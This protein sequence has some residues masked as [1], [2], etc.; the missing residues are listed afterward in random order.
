[1]E[2]KYFDTSLVASPIIAPTDC[3]G[4]E[5]DPVTILC[6]NGVPQGD[7]ASSR[8]G[9][10]IAMKSLY[11]E[12]KVVCAAQANQ[13]ASDSGTTVLIAVVLDTQTNGAQ[14]N[15]EDVYINPAGDANLASSP[16][17][18]MSFTERFK[19]LKQKRI[20]IRQ[21]SMVYDGTNVE[22]AGQK[23][24]FRMAIN[25]GGMLTKFQTGTTTGYVGTIIDN[26][27]HVVAYADGTDLS[28][29]LYYN[30]RLRYRG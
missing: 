4:G 26:S 9:M 28:P 25:L 6:L 29:V 1:M 22:Q 13:T 27:I 23:I 19:V 2:T 18:D 24:P 3:S 17:R 21:P 30:A 20:Q 5:H 16:L 12:G 11:I 10:K 8:D 14:L 7:T 15:S